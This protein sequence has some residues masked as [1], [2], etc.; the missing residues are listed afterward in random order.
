MCVPRVL[1][2]KRSD[3]QEGKFTSVTVGGKEILIANI[4][5]SYF[6]TGNICTH[7]GAELHEGELHDKQLICPW[8]GARWDLTTGQLIWFQELLE[9]IGS[10]RIV[11]EGDTL[12][13]DL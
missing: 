6:A 4:Q 5:G 7:E 9:S 10:Y 13:V 12:F 11:I 3:I 2:G 1:V 8:H